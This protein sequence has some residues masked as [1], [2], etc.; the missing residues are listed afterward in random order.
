MQ[1]E[2]WTFALQ[3]CFQNQFSNLRSCQTENMQ[4][5]V[6][7]YFHFPKSK[8]DSESNFEMRRSIFPFKKKIEALQW[9]EKKLRNGF[10]IVFSKMDL[11]DVGFIFTFEG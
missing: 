4:I 3:N 1:S 7:A 9:K 8:I 6:F 10:P 5:Y 11:S 2:I